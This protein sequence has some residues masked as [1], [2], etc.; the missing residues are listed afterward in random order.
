MKIRR[1]IDEIE[2]MNK[3]PENIEIVYFENYAT[4]KSELKL[5]SSQ[6]ELCGKTF[7]KDLMQYI[8]NGGDAKNITA[9]NVYKKLGLEN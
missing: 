6:V 5:Y 8:R 7:A 4:R 2:K 3:L 9:D 1:D